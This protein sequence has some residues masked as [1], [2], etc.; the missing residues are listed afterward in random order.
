MT[1]SLEN[2]LINIYF[3]N[4]I[5]PIRFGAL[6]DYEFFDA[7]PINQDDV[8]ESE[9]LKYREARMSVFSRGSEPTQQLETGNVTRLF[10]KK[11]IKKL[12]SKV[13]HNSTIRKVLKQL[14]YQ[15]PQN[16]RNFVIS[17]LSPLENIV[18]SGTSYS[19]DLGFGIRTSSMPRISIIIPVFN[20][21]WVTYRCLRAIQKT[22][23]ISEFEIIVIDDASSDLTSQ[24]LKSVRGIKV[25][26]NKRNLG[27]LE[28]TNLGAKFR[29]PSSEFLL[30]LNNDTEPLGNWLDELLRVFESNGRAAIVGST[31]FYPDGRLQESGA[32]IFSAGNG[33]NIG[34]LANFNELFSSL[35]QVD[36]CSAAS[37]MI[38]TKFWEEASGF[39]IRYKPAYYEDSDLAMYAWS[40]GYEVL[41]SPKS[42]VIHHEGTSH[43]TSIKS[44]VK[45]YQSINRTR[46]VNKW[47]D[48]LIEHWLD[49]DYPR[50]EFS[51]ESKGIVVMCDYQLP[52]ESRDSGSQ[53]TIRIAELLMKLNYHVVIACVDNS[54]RAIQ[55]EKLRSAGVEVFTDHK[56]FYESLRLRSKRLRLF[57]AIREETFNYFAPNL[58]SLNTSIPLVADLLDI[59]FDDAQ[60]KKISKK[61]I[62]ISNLSDITILVSPTEAAA[63]SAETSTKVESLWYDFPVRN[64]EYVSLGRSGIIF[65]GGFRHIPNHQ[66]I[67]WFATEVLPLIRERGF[68]EEV[69]II[70]SGLDFDTTDTLSRL[71][72]TVVGYQKDL[73]V[74]Y[75]S[76]KV[77]IV[78]LKTGA[79]LKGKLAE[80]LSFGL[81]VITTSIGAEGFFKVTSNDS[82]F[83][84]NDSAED[85]ANAILKV[86]T[87]VA[88]ATSISQNA[89]RYTET[90]L[91]ESA[92]LVKL[93]GLL[94]KNGN[95]QSNL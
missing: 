41:I 77:A 58:R 18:E 30:L 48:E 93:V 19:L 75:N 35:R 11:L 74:F 16:K 7:V 84:V 72:C 24:A 9:F 51:R 95:Q 1:D 62:A 2:F 73:D 45:K 49:A 60:Q 6:M 37:I 5:V 90:Y 46:F 13:K 63:L 27:Y 28:S 83:L 78:P 36:Y 87:D 23:N 53:R 76:S 52:D 42:W 50:V 56:D 68:T 70:G 21:W 64:S 8:L 59:R 85:F 86:V 4:T 25:V 29:H 57:W 43:G 65:V 81:P 34:R 89:I 61:Q 17:S 71:G 22:D 15:L 55:L 39:D 94:E 20:H 44:G 88:Y 47:K 92:M 33:W 69:Y 40:S 10:L 31:L 3:Y 32:Q 26:R 12:S 67:M 80:A 82:P 66:G 38:T 79:G 54:A 14:I 91:S